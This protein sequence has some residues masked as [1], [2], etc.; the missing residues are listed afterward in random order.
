MIERSTDI[1]I[2]HEQ[3]LMRAGLRELLKEHGFAVSAE[4]ADAK[5]AVESALRVRPAVCLLQVWMPGGGVLAAREITEQLTDTAV[6]MIGGEGG[7][8]ELLEA[9][10]AGAVGYLPPDTDPKRLPEALRGV[11]AGEAAVPRSL[12]RQLIEDLRACGRRPYLDSPSEGRTELTTREWEVISLIHEGLST[13]E[14]ARRLVV[15]PITIRRHLST[16]VRKLGVPDR[17][18][19][20]RLLDSRV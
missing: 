13:T 16:V 11:L 17:D 19:A 7:G 8:L 4:A 12:V 5:S 10:H 15:S 3:P 1:L 14:A 18:A 9:V 20:V 6:V 2:A